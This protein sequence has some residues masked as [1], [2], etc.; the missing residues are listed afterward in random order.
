MD[1]HNIIKHIGKGTFQTFIHVK[2]K[3]KASHS[4]L[5]FGGIYEF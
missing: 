3:N 4:I 5:S 2:K 1:E